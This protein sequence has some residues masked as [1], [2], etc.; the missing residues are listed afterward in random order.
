MPRYRFS[1]GKV[2]KETGPYTPVTRDRT[3][4]KLGVLIL[5]HGL[6]RK[7][8]RQSQNPSK[9]EHDHVQQEK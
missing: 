2:H 1:A 4:F 9:G 3:A 5:T 7:D 6:F 8:T